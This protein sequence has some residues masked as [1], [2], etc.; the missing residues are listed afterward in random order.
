MI[1]QKVRMMGRNIG[2]LLSDA[3]E[4]HPDGGVF[5][6]ELPAESYFEAGSESL[7]FLIGNGMEGDYVSFQRPSE[8][9]SE[10]LEK[11]GINVSKIIFIDVASGLGGKKERSG[12]RCVHIGEGI[13]IDELSRAVYTTLPK[14]K[15]KKFI[16]IDSLTTIALHKPLSEMMRLFE[17]LVMETRK[18][19]GTVL[20]INVARELAQKKFIE[21]VAV[22]ADEIISVD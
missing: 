6:I 21:D 13:E 2:K 4:R 16:Y 10:L 15:G 12:A 22:H 19:K 9:V 18:A 17:F 11:G 14:L 3:M 20:I 5:L 8:N 7:R 1:V